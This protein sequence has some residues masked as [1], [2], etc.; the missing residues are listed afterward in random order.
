MRLSWLVAL[1][2]LALGCHRIGAPAS[3]IPFG[4]EGAEAGADG[5][6]NQVATAL[7]FDLQEGRFKDAHD[8]A[9]AGFRQ[10]VPL[11]TFR[12][13]AQAHPFPKESGSK[14]AV[15]KESREGSRKYEYRFEGITKRLAFSFTVSKE[16]AKYQITDMKY[17]Q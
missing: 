11:D 17:E 13:E 5:P 1:C 9:S 15:M 16:G 2:L 14:A 8:R 3:K 4:P 12:Q 6:Y 10:R 7:L